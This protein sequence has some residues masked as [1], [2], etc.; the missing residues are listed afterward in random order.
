M[1]AVWSQAGANHRNAL[2]RRTIDH[3]IVDL[4]LHRP[5]LGV[6]VGE[7]REEA[8]GLLR[9]SGEVGKVCTALDESSGPQLHQDG[10][11]GRYAV[12]ERH[13]KRVGCAQ[14]RSFL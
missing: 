2:E 7:R 8:L 1:C 13:G 9:E 3:H 11:L 12:R 4:H 6:E 5:S 10:R 14:R